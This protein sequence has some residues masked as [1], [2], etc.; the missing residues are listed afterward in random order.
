MKQ[1]GGTYWTFG[2]ANLNRK[3]QEELG[4]GLPKTSLH[5]A[6]LRLEFGSIRKCI[7]TIPA[8]FKPDPELEIEHV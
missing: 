5:V 1:S 8:T 6:H 4:F 2:R 3:S 7:H